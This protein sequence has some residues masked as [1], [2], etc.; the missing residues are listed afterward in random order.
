[1]NYNIFPKDVVVGKGKLYGNLTTRQT[2]LPF[3]IGQCQNFIK[4]NSAYLGL[5]LVISRGKRQDAKH[6]VD[7]LDKLQSYNNNLTNAK[8]KERTELSYVLK[9]YIEDLILEYATP[10][11]LRSAIDTKLW[12]HGKQ[13][14]NGIRYILHNLLEI[15][16]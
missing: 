5:N 1:M 12:S 11:Q 6:I 3:Y 10:D 8:L 16:D 13:E 15:E 7:S 14:R 9:K 4:I 2:V